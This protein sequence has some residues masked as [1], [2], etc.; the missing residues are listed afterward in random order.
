MVSVN[1]ATIWSFAS[2]PGGLD[3]IASVISCSKAAVLRA[4]TV[5]VLLLSRTVD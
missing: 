3:G 2:C 5:A 1:C 4:A